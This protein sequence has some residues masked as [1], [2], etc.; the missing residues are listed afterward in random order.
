ML[1]ENGK[2][3]VVDAS[4][5]GI[6]LALTQREDYSGYLSQHNGDV[7]ALAGVVRQRAAMLLGGPATKPN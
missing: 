7:K 3:V 6:W 4:V 5:E 2:F 1:N